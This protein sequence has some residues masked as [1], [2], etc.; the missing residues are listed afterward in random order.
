MGSRVLITAGWYKFN[1]IFLVH[2]EKPPANDK[3]H[4]EKSEVE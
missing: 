2:H 1:Q 3:S 4:A